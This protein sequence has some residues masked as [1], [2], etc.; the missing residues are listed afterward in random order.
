M[1]LQSLADEAAI[2]QLSAFY[3]DA[4]THLDARR[5]ASIYAEDGSVAIAGNVIAGRA[6]IEAGMRQSFAEF[7]LLQLIAHGGLIAID[8]DTAQARWS[9]IELTIRKNAPALNVIFG[10]YEDRL[11]RQP[12]GWRFQLREFT[13]A[14]RTQIDVAKLQLNPSFFS[15]LDPT[16]LATISLATLGQQDQLPQSSPCASD[17]RNPG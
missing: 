5:A 9:T 3:S 6:A 8:G 15:L 16:A 7:D 14:G 17:A 10:R 2:R 13:M 4:V 1:S 11:V 12:G